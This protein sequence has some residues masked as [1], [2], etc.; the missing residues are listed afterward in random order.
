MSGKAKSYRWSHSI[1]MCA[2]GYRNTGCAKA[3]AIKRRK[4]P[5]T[6]KHVFS[7]H[8]LDIWIEWLTR[9]KSGGDLKEAGYGIAYLDIGEVQE[10]KESEAAQ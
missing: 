3:W 4:R 8:D 10:V 5:L 1:M 2:V 9:L 6:E 7:D